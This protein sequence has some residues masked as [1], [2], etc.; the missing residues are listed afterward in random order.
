LETG[1]L[2]QKVFTMLV[3]MAVVTTVMTGP[4]LTLTMSRLGLAVAKAVEA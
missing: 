1:F 3:I 2:P 4:L